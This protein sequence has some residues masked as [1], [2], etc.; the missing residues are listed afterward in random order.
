M[1]FPYPGT[2]VRG[3]QSGAP[4]MALF[5]LLGRRWAMGVLWTLRETEP[6]KF[7]QLQ[8]RCETI[9]PSVLNKRLAELREARLI[10]RGEGGYVTT[11]LGRELYDHITPLGAW[12]KTWAEALGDERS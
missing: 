4:V 11:Q 2:P 12:A 8:D 6:A 10:E 9:S 1:T 3:S 7:R 5:D